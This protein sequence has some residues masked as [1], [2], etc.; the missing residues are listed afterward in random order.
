[1]VMPSSENC[2]TISSTIRVA[3]GSRA[4][5]GSSRKHLGAHRPG[6]GERKAPLLA[7]PD[8]SRAGWS[9]SGVSPKRSS[10]RAT[11]PRRPAGAR[12]FGASGQSR[13]A[14]TER[15]GRTGRRKTIACAS[16]RAAP[17]RA[18][19][20]VFGNPVTGRSSIQFRSGQAYLQM[21][22]VRNRFRHCGNGPA[23]EPRR[24]D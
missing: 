5:E 23:V 10:V 6:A 20:E 16:A 3:E 1:M 18:R 13:F 11:L 21:I 24:T 4:E 2:A 7:P 8:G 22:I 12:P 9:A 14:A 17:S 19:Q 15:R